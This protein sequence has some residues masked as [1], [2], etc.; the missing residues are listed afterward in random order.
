METC[1]KG[2]TDRFRNIPANSG[3]FRHIETQSCIFRNYI[4]FLKR[5]AG[6]IVIKNQS[7]ERSLATM[8]IFTKINV[9]LAKLN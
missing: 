5:L 1:K 9:P 2:Q 6:Q 7:A 4:I 8:R 3:I